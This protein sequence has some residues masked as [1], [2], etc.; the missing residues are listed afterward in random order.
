VPGDP[1]A[2][3]GLRRLEP[4]TQE[5]ERQADSIAELEERLEQQR[6][7]DW[8]AYG[9]ALQA[10]VEAE[11]ARLPGLTVPVVVRVQ[12]ETLPA[13]DEQSGATWKLVD[14]L[15][16]VAMQVTEPPGDGR[17]PLARLEATG[18]AS[19]R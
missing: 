4:A 15:L 19:A 13:A 12:Q 16:T 8:T 9:R 14:Q 17:P 2:E 7:E 10:A 3:E 6:L 18:P 11:A 5:Q 1:L